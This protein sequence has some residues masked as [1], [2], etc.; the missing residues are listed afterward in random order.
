MFV[1]LLCALHTPDNVLLV[2]LM[3]LL[4]N[5]I[6]SCA[7]S[8]EEYYTQGL[9]LAQFLYACPRQRSIFPIST[10]RVVIDAVADCDRTWLS[11][12]ILITS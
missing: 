10:I 3:Q 1:L 12:K 4:I 6:A 11:S 9:Y 5:A 7:A 8:S 2:L